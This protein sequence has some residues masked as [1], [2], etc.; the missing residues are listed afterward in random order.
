MEQLLVKQLLITIYRCTNLH[1]DSLHDTLVMDIKRK[2]ENNCSEQY[3]LDRLAKHYNV[4]ISSLS[5]R[6]RAVTGT[7]VMKYLASC[8][9][10][11]AK[12]LLIETDR[13]IG[14]IVENCGFSDNSNFSRTFKQLNG[15]SPTD[16]RKQYKAE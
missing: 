8:R 14:E 2:F 3:A 16:F 7:S 6:F 15:M 1:F 4:S 12:Q 10:A 13:S 11:H 5:H 9:I